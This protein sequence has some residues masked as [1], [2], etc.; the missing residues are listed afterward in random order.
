MQ[1]TPTFWAA[2][3]AGLA[4]PTALYAPTA[5]YAA[6]IARPNVGNTFALVGM[7]L[8]RVMGAPVNVGQTTHRYACPS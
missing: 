1:F 6:Y 8:T 2:F 3:W 7:G 5:P 4:A